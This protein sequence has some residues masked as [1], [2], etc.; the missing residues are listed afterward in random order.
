[1]EYVDSREVMEAMSDS[2]SQK[3]MLAIIARMGRRDDAL[4]EDSTDRVVSVMKE[5]SGLILVAAFVQTSP[6]SRPGT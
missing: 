5:N 4:M 1:M 6:A 2:E 3:E